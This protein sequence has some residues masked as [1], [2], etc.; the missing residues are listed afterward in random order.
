M[1]PWQFSTPILWASL[2]AWPLSAVIL[3][4]WLDGFADHM[5]L[6]PWPCLAASLL[7]LVIAL[8]TV[9]THAV[10]IARAKPVATLR[11]E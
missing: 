4:H 5:E 10:L 3:N 8:L 7:A 1:R 9:G 11:Y 2:L 6:R